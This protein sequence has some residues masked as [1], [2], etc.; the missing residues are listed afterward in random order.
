[1]EL[2]EEVVERLDPHS[3]RRAGGGDLKWKNIPV[4]RG[5][6]RMRWANVSAR[7]VRIYLKRITVGE[8]EVVLYRKMSGLTK[9][10]CRSK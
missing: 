4:E 10:G 7:V 9:K 5:T 2:V 8:R 1:M 3:R 6:G